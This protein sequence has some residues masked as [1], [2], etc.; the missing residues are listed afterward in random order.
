LCH[1]KRTLPVGGELVCTFTGKYAPEHQIVHLELPTIHKLLVIAPKHLAVPCI[2]ER[3]LPSS[4]FDEV[5]IITLN[6]VLRNFIVCLNTR[7]GHGDFWGITASVP[8]T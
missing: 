2:L 7:G 6:L 1:R 8:Y 5:D 3:C 4:F